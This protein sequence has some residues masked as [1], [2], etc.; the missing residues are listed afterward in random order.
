[1]TGHAAIL[2]AAFLAVPASTAAADQPSWNDIRP[3]AKEGFS[4][5]ECYCT[6]SEGKRVDVGETACLKIGNRRFTA[7]CGMSLNNPAWRTEQ[8]GCPGV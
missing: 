5:P 4:Y 1:M 7:R 8:E 6:D 3:P 2:L